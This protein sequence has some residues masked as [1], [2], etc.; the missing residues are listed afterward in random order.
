M[1]PE[2]WAYAD[3]ATGTLELDSSVDS[4]GVS[5]GQRP[6]APPGSGLGER[7]GTGDADSEGEVGVSVK[8]GEHFFSKS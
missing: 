2:D 1:C 7:L 5:A 6:E 3:C 4:I 8:V